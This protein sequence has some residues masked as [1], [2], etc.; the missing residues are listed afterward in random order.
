MT[1]AK[2]AA[3]TMDEQGNETFDMSGALD[4]LR[5]SLEL[6]RLA[7][8]HDSNRCP[9]KLDKRWEDL[10]PRE[11]IEIFQDGINE[12]S[13]GSTLVSPWARD[14]TY[15][16]SPINGDLKY[17]RL[18][19][20]ERNDSSVPFEKASLVI[21]DVSLTITENTCGSLS[22]KTHG[23]SFRGCRLLVALCC[24]SWVAAEEDVSISSE[25]KVNALQASFVHAPSGENVDWRL[26]AI[27]SPCH[28]TKE[29]VKL[30]LRL[31]LYDLALDDCYI[32]VELNQFLYYVYV[33]FLFWD[34]TE[35]EA[36]ACFVLVEKATKTLLIWIYIPQ[37]QGIRFFKIV[38]DG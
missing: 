16:V 18:G 36:E 33:L 7:M 22:F 11:W 19:N 20:Q 26:S 1:L 35:A 28:A 23:A 27:I 25:Q 17:H 9:W 37:S 29:I 21:T 24:T 6:E 30:F 10:S 2:H 8:Y 4:K 15:L 5:K 12:S 13:K 34:M 38:G 31:F 14:R 3:V 32:R